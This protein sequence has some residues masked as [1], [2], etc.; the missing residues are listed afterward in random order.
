MTRLSKCLLIAAAA[1]AS[2]AP[3]AF[4]QPISPSAGYDQTAIDEGSW[5]SGLYNDVGMDQGIQLGYFQVAP[6]FTGGGSFGYNST[7]LYNY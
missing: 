7:V 4:A 5:H 6:A 1:T 2:A 3:S